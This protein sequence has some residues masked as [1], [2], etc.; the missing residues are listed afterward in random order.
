MSEC[1]N[2]SLINA[3]FTPDFFKTEANECL[4]TCISNGKADENRN[5]QVERKRLRISIIAMFCWN[6]K[7]QRKTE[8]CTLSV[9]KPLSGQLPKR[10]R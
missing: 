2:A 10:Y 5:G 9:T 3:I 4:A 1:P 7:T 8:Y 6:G